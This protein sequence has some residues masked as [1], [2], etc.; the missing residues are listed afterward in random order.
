MSN[1]ASNSIHPSVD[2][3]EL[4]ALDSSAAVLEVLVMWGESSVLHAEYLPAGACFWVGEAPSGSGREAVQFTLAL[5]GAAPSR[6]ALAV[7]EEGGP[8]VF[9]PDGARCEVHRQGRWCEATLERYPRARTGVPGVATIPLQAGEQAQL[10]WLGLRFV[11]RS[12]AAVRA[13]GKERARGLRARDY[14]W[15]FASLSV[16]AAL[17]LLFSL[18]PPHSLALSID[19]DH[20]EL[21]FA[22]YLLAKTL[23]PPPPAPSAQTGG[24]LGAAAS[25]ASESGEGRAA[26]SPRP[27]KRA[28]VQ[29]GQVD[30]PAPVTRARARTSA[31]E[32]GIIGVLRSGLGP[33]GQDVYVPGLGSVG[34]E[35]WLALEGTGAGQRGIG[36]G[37]V[38]TGRGGGR[39]AEGTIGIGKLATGVHGGLGALGPLGSRTIR[40]PPPSAPHVR[41]EGGLAK[42]AIRRVIQLHVKEVRFCY[43]QSLQRRPDLQG[44]VLVQF[45]IGPS[46]EVKIASGSAQDAALNE[47]VRCIASSVQRWQFPAPAGGGIVRVQYP[48]ML[49]FTGG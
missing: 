45:A 41:V 19:R 43:E 36:V 18:Q 47:V 4:A 9:V 17:L 27:R 35:S 15:T 24:D 37:M 5:P 8:R 31:S 29:P 3:P 16:H 22:D 25:A 1:A 12:C 34:S 21:R 42:E 20:G 30:T 7:A 23:L 33:L 11:V 32:A 46:G 10:R 14:T 38:G 13:V 49:Q 48:F 26:P 44:R 39:G 2:L 40:I 6:V 28:S